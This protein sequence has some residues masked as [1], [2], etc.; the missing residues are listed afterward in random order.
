MA[1][2]LI[3]GEALMG[4]LVAIPIA[5]LKPHDINFPIIEHLTGRIMP[6]G[7]VVGIVLLA[8]VTLW[9]YVTTVRRRQN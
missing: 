8:F 4:I 7:G 1:S 5:L 9:L 2:G 3:T 6:G